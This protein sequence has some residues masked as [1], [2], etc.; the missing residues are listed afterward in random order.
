MLVECLKY[1]SNI[2]EFCF[3]NQCE[4]KFTK[5][6]HSSTEVDCF[7]NFAPHS[8]SSGT[9]ASIQDTPISSFELVVERVV[10]A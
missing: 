5:L 3:F 10:F 9:F 8:S 4:H 7:C 6:V 2:L 1:F